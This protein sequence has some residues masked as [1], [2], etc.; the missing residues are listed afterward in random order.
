MENHVLQSR[1]TARVAVRVIAGLHKGRRLFSSTGSN[2]RPTSGRV[3]EAIF[4]ILGPGIKGTHFLDLYAGTGAVGIEALSRGARRVIFV[5]SDPAS[6][7]L[8]HANIRHCQLSTETYVHAGHAE[9]FFEQQHDSSITFDIVFADP[10]Y[11][12]DS[13][14]GLLPSLERSD[15]IRTNTIV[16]LEHPAKNRIPSQIGRLRRV[17]HYRY[18][19]TSLSKFTI[20]SPEIHPS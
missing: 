4:S 3:K 6:L 14:A 17:R 5:E 16:L 1:L 7:R 11:L 13:A 20:S 9:E 15:M 8:L 19:D 10:P 12:L 2:L 18:G